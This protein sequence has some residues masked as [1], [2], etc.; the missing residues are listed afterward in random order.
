M[1]NPPAQQGRTLG[2]IKHQDL[3]PRVDVLSLAT[4]G[5]S[6]VKSVVLFG[7]WDEGRAHRFGWAWGKL[8]ELEVAMPDHG[9]AI[10]HLE[11]H[12]E[13]KENLLTYVCSD[14]CFGLVLT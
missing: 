6:A 13:L 8:K 7:D 5:K 14:L 2:K 3:G 10:K 4:A 12:P 9:R 11:K 1:F